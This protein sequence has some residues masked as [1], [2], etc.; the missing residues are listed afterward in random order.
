MGEK[1]SVSEPDYTFEEFKVYYEST[2][3]VTDRRIAT[4]RWNYSVGVA[5]LGG[6]ALVIKLSLEKSTFFALGLF[7]AAIVSAIAAIFSYL[8]L[9]QVDDFKSLN[10]A[11]FMVLN[12]MAPKIRFPR[13]ADD[14]PKAPAIKSYE[15]FRREWE[16]LERSRSLV[17]VRGSRIN[18]SAM[19]ASNI[20]RFI[21][22]CF[23]LLFS[24]TTLI[25][26]IIG[27]SNWSGLYDSLKCTV[28]GH[29]ED[30]CTST[31]TTT[32]TSKP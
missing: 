6:L 25:S 29:G 31:T 27:L 21:P 10:N 9:R 11:K 16:E 30:Q 18:I 17:A 13:Q 26:L 19:S 32:T 3:R 2:E 24:A 8:W 20:E 23:L 22:K 12:S 15:P 7:A 14:D 1:S 4:T 5:I 28:G